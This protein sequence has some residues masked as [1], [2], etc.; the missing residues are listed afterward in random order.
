V[1]AA[2]LAGA[3]QGSI[4]LQL[5]RVVLGRVV[6]MREG[7]L[8]QVRSGIADLALLVVGNNTHTSSTVTRRLCI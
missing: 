7:V 5:A 2:V 4:G 8:H 3:I 6:C 1:V